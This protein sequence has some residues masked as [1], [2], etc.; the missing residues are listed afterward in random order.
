ML[1]SRTPAPRGSCPCTEQRTDC[2][3][4]SGGARAWGHHGSCW[5]APHAAHTHSHLLRLCLQLPSGNSCQIASDKQEG[6]RN[7]QRQAT[8]EAE[9]LSKHFT[10]SPSQAVR[11]RRAVEGN[12]IPCNISLL[13]QHFVFTASRAV[14]S[15]TL[16]GSL[17]GQTALGLNQKSLQAKKIYLF[18]FKSVS[19]SESHKPGYSITYQRSKLHSNFLNL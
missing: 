5:G 13:W 9:V 4:Q 6:H 17:K 16:R 1:P 2:C 18:I 15:V 12:P 7:C 14:V 3:S 10:P 19:R 8:F 11:E